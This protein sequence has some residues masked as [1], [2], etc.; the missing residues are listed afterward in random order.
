M[1]FLVYWGKE[2]GVSIYPAAELEDVE[3]E[4]AVGDSCIVR[5]GKSKDSLFR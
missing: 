4:R 3:W 5:F 2:E 1:I